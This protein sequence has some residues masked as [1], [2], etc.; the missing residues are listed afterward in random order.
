MSKLLKSLTVL[1]AVSSSFIQAKEICFVDKVL[2]AQKSV[3]GKKVGLQIQSEIKAFQDKVQQGQQEL[4]AMQEALSKKSKVLSKKAIE[5]ENRKIAQKKKDL[6]RTLGD[7]EEFLKSTIEAKNKDLSEKID[8]AIGEVCKKQQF[9]A[10]VDRNVPGF[11]FV[12]NTMDRS[13][14]VVKEFDA[15]AS[16]KAPTKTAA[17]TTIKK[18]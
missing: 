10:V 7:R 11:Y 9:G 13:D 2:I 16:Q 4:M 18:A 6:E 5:D 15:M 14:L 12:D 1:L 17:T 8:K 3:E